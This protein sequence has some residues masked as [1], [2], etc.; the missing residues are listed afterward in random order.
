MLTVQGDGHPQIWKERRLLIQS[1]AATH[2]A[3]VSLQERLHKAQQALQ[4]LT[5]RRQGEPRLAERT[6]VEEAIQDVLTRFRV[7]GL[8][9]V[10]IQEHVQERPVRAYRG[11]RLPTRHHVTFTAS[12]QREEEAIENAMRQLAWRVSPPTHLPHPPTLQ[13]P[14]TAHP[15]TH[16]L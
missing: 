8:L 2:A 6:A 11:R 7:E 1:I 4:E 5:A 10:Q 12:S 16:L 9:R 14:V 3:Q 13:P 15:H